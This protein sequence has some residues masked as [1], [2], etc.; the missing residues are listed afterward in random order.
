MNLLK[1][2]TNDLPD[3]TIEIETN[4][5]SPSFDSPI[6]INI[7]RDTEKQI[8]KAVTKIENHMRNNMSGL[9]NIFSSKTYPS[10]E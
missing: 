2:S 4:E 5:R 1:N 6:E 8:N 7:F 10:V 9:N 3:I